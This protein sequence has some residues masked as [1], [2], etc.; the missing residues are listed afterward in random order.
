[1]AA[2]KIKVLYVDDERNNLLSFKATFRKDYR[3]FIA[4]SGKEGL[5]ILEQNKDMHVIVTD[6][7]MPEMT[8]IEFLT[9][10]LELYPDP[11]RILLTGYSDINAVVDAINKGQVYRYISKPWNEQEFKITIKNAFE[12]YALREE[13]KKLTRDLLKIN[14]QLE[15]VLRQKIIS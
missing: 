4:S 13:N 7:R 11:I 8:G 9:A 3:V 14:Q 6:Q 12:I 2:D 5:E 15:F 1:M 10:V